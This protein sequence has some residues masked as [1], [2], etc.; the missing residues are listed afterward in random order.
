MIKIKYKLDN[1]LYNNNNNNK[2][3]RIIFFIY[4]P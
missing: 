2:Y 1:I 3:A 4:S